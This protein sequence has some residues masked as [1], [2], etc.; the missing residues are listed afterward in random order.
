MYLTSADKLNMAT[1]KTTTVDWSSSWVDVSTSLTTPD[2]TKGT[3][4]AITT[5]IVVTSPAASTVRLVKNVYIFNR[6]V[7]DNVTVTITI[8]DG[9]GYRVKACTLQTLESLVYTDTTGWR[10][11]RSDGTEKTALLISAP[12]PAIN[13]GPGFSTASLTGVKTITTANSFAR[14]MGKAPR[15]L[16][17]V[18]MRYRVTTAAATITWAE[19]ALAKGVPVLGGNPSLTV[20]GH[21]DVSAIINSTGQKSTTIT[22][23]STQ[24]I[25]EGDD[26]WLLIGNQAT[27]AAIVRAQSMADDLQVGFQ[28]S[29]ASRP[30]LIV[31]ASTSFTLESATAL[32][33]WVGI[34]Y[35]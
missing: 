2:A 9:T 14:Y 30:S 13:L 12:V 22:V 16:T 25:S 31:G 10:V 15:P 3:V 32:A 8:D 34:Q 27:T 19:V 5:T 21:I 11:Y 18:A 29:A 4:A 26:L 35:P 6:S 1:D 24:S 33:A 17:S 28:A 23:A 7:A 20:V